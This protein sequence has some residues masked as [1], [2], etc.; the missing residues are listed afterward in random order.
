M[1]QYD[2]AVL[3]I[4]MLGIGALTRGQ[5]KLDDIDFDAW[6]LSASDR[7]HQ[8]FA[9]KLLQ[10]FRQ[11]LVK[12]QASFET[13]LRV[14]QLSDC[15]FLWS[16]NAAVVVN[17]ARDLMW[18]VTRVGLLCRAGL[19]YGQIVE[20]EKVNRSMGAFVLGD[21]VTKAV[22]L[23]QSGKGCRV[24]CD[25]EIARSI[26]KSHHFKHLPFH[27][28]RNPLDGSVTDE[29]R[30]YL[31]PDPIQKRNYLEPQRLAS[32]L[33]Q[34]EVLAVLRYGPRL[35]WNCSSSA[36]HVQIACSVEAVSAGLT[37][38]FPH[39]DFEYTAEHVMLT[40]TARSESA[41]DKVTTM[42]AG[43]IRQQLT[44]PAATRKRNRIV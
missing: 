18:R 33:A 30:W 36:G 27:G 3:F 4:D 12:V 2:G 24:F 20:P 34:A 25:T 23:E 14:A 15:A 31:L 1:K 38:F 6:G 7:Q 16:A 8:L 29:F 17:A 19:A 13:T 40:K 9:A 26:L 11:C 43:E 5:V 44:S 32:A 35:N 22:G 10:Q 39:E 28:L 37:L 21:A 42:W 41:L